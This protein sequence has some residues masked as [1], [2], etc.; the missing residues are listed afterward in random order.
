LKSPQATAA[1]L[2][3]I[4]AFAKIRELSRVVAKLSQ[5]KEKPQQQSLMQK[6]GDIIAEL[7]ESGMVA[8]GTETT[9]EI[10]LAV[11]RFRHVIKKEKNSK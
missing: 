2:A 1:T 7:L 3:I 8:S 11:M 4:E 9:F 6:G 10:N 5:I